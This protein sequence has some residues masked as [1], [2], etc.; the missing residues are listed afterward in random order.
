M[1]G[2]LL[3]SFGIYNHARFRCVHCL[4]KT[5]VA[6]STLQWKSLRLNSTGAV[7]YRV[8]ALKRIEALQR[9]SGCTLVEDVSVVSIERVACARLEVHLSAKWLFRWKGLPLTV[10]QTCTSCKV[11]LRIP[12]MTISVPKNLQFRTAF[13]CLCMWYLTLVSKS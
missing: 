13:W 8:T 3:P 5:Q 1:A 6:S 4:C 7:D 10:L 11:S 9:S 2:S 12:N